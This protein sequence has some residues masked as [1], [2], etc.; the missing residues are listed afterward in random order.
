MSPALILPASGVGYRLMVTAPALAG[1]GPLGGSVVFHVHT[2]VREDALVLYGFLTRQER[3]CFELLIAA[4]GVGPALALAILSAHTPA[5]LRAAVLT[6][7]VDALTL[8]AGVGKKTAA[9]LVIELTSKFESSDLDLDLVG[10]VSV[11]PGPGTGATVDD[12]ADARADVRAALAELG[13]GADE[14]RS[15]LRSLP[16]GADASSLLKAALAML[17]EARR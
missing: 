2:H 12:S 7:D 5:S 10:S 9:R 6:E 1:L 15:V 4:H 3:M 14:V 16:G 13:Y 8:V 17:A 11:S